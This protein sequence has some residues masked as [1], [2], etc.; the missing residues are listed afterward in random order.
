[1]LDEQQ[2]IDDWELLDQFSHHYRN[3]LNVSMQEIGIH[4][5]QAKVLCRLFVQ[6]GMSQSEIAQA[7]CL[8]GA[9]ITDI[10]QRM[11]VAGL[12]YRRRDIQ[13]NRLVRI[14]LT[15]SGR[16][17]E[18]AITRQIHKLESQ[19]FAEMDTDEQLVLQQLLMKVIH[20]MK[21][22]L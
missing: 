9:T 10:L 4:R 11:E 13:D 21:S 19:M 8:H 6:D 18:Q 7:L 1:M 20:T 5:S 2:K 22:K 3:L 17:K 14:Y 16:E 15:D 12:I